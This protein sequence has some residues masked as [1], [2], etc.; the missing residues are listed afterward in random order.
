MITKVATTEGIQMDHN[1]GGLKVQCSTAPVRLW[2]GALAVIL[3]VVPLV[4]SLS[5]EGA[6][7]SPTGVFTL[8]MSPDGSNDWDGRTPE[9]ALETLG[10]VQTKLIRYKPTIDQNIEVRI[11]YDSSKPY[12]GQTVVWTHTSP[13][14][15]ISFM[16]SDYQYGMGISGIAGRPVFDGGGSSDWFFQLKSTKGQPTNVRFYYL[17]IHGYVP[18]AIYLRGDP[19][20]WQKWNGYNL[21]YGCYFYNLGNQND[22]VAAYGFGAVTL[23]NSDYNTIRNNVFKKLVN[24]PAGNEKYIHGVYLLNNS[25]N[26]VIQ[27]NNFSYISGDPIKVRDYSNY[28]KIYSNSFVRTGHQAFLLDAPKGDDPD[29]CNSWRN[30]FRYNT[31]LSCGYHGQAILRYKRYPRTPSARCPAL[32]PLVRWSDN[33][34]EWCP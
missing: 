32:Q 7:E 33:D 11:L 6:S 34:P 16:P 31:P 15:T 22:P 18:G 5:A 23:K 3:V 25:G 26:N 14:Y 2:L 1:A 9:T 30:E 13:S 17:R 12:H 29:E 28:N 27:H 21:V 24:V 19:N 8:Y 4:S 10:G 20:E